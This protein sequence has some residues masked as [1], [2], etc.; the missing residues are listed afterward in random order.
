R[1]DLLPH[2]GRRSMI[3]LGALMHGLAHARQVI[4]AVDQG[5]V[6][7]RLRKIADQALG[8]RIVFLAQQADFVAKSDQPPEQ[9][10]GFVE[11]LLQNVNVDQP[12]AAGQEGALARRQ[13]VFHVLGAVAQDETVA[14][15]PSLDRIDRADN[16]R[17]GYRQEAD[18]RQQQQAGVELVATI[19]LHECTELRVV[20]PRADVVANLVTQFAPIVDWPFEAEILRALDGA[21]ESDPGH[22]LGIGEMLSWASHFP[23]ALVRLAPN[24]RQIFEK[25]GLR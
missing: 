5:Q 17:I 11:A 20:T 10:F 3:L 19:G 21:I 2:R 1:P 16:A 12:E 4:G 14:D 24:P 25:L 9:V 23:D 6:R 8:A 7:K 13:R 18:A 15:E 22:D